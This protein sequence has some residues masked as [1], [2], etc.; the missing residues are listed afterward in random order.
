MDKTKE[1]LKKIDEIE[2]RLNRVEDWMD[3]LILAKQRFEKG[4][5][6]KFS[7]KAHRKGLVTGKRS[8]AKTGRVVEV[9][10]HFSIKVLLKGYKQPISF[11]HSLFDFA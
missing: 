5:R 6:V 10:E 2:I 8:K 9:S 4:D 11:H 3:W 7:G 1:M